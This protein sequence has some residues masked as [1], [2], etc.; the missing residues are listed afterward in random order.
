MSKKKNTNNDD[1]LFANDFLKMFLKYGSMLAKADTGTDD[2]LYPY[3][4]GHAS[5]VVDAVE[6]VAYHLYISLLHSPVKIFRRITVP[7]NL[8]LEHLAQIIIRTMGWY[9]CHLHQFHAQNRQYAPKEDEESGNMSWL[10]NDIDAMSVTVNDVLKEKG[11]SIKLEYDFGDSWM[12]QVRLSAIDDKDRSG[13]ITVDSGTGGCPPE[14]AS[15]VYGY[16]EMLED[17][18]VSAEPFDL[19]KARLSVAAYVNDV[20]ANEKPYV[21]GTKET[22]EDKDR[23]THRIR[24]QKSIH[25]KTIKTLPY[26]FTVSTIRALHPRTLPPSSTDQDYALLANRLERALLTE[27]M[28]EIASPEAMKAI[29]SRV[30]MYY[31]DIIA[32]AGMWRAFVTK[33]RELY[34][35]PYPFYPVD[36]EVYTDEP[37]INAVRLLLWDAFRDFRGPHTI[38]NPENPYLNKAAQ[39]LYD[40]LDSEFENTP[41]NEPL[42]DY[43]RKASFA[44]DFYELR[45]VLKWILF[46]C[47]LT[48]DAYAHEMVTENMDEYDPVMTGTNAYYSAECATPM[49][50]QVGMLA[51][52]PKDWL[53]LFISEVGDKQT[54]KKI[55][56]I[57]TTGFIDVLRKTAYDKNT[58]SFVDIDDKAIIIERGYSYDIAEKDVECGYGAIG[59]YAKYDGKWYLNGNQSWGNVEEYFKTCQKEKH[60]LLGIDKEHYDSLMKQ[61]GGSPIFY[62]KNYRQLRKFFKEQAGWEGLDALKP[63]HEEKDFAVYVPEANHAIA[64]MPE[65]AVFIKDPRNPCYDVSEASYNALSIIADGSSAPGEFVRYLISHRMVPDARINSLKGPA[66]GQ[67]LIQDNIDFFARAYRRKD[68]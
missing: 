46:D 48:S 50:C 36:G 64:T 58:I 32:D 12:H 1:S 24:S 37:D 62:V 56:D 30:I 14:D 59:C 29:I 9:N 39:I 18:E 7:A 5:L 42:A 40:I 34:S 19:G 68:Y 51:L 26:T 43:F 6:P 16:A 31:E 35:L 49:L 11:K 54:A 28:D 17:G 4:E 66:Y 33:C 45:D 65:A 10:S 3:V 38:I 52:L 22:G 47:Y 2:V 53:A 61:S 8:R 55:A 15:G 20:V 21:E 13:K 67:R 27:Q 63:F 25:A 60:S 57:E 23:S 44:N 41:I